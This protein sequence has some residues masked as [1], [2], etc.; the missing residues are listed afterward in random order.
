MREDEFG[1]LIGK[2]DDSRDFFRVP[3]FLNDL[4]ACHEMERA[5]WI[6]NLE[7]LHNDADVNREWKEYLARLHYNV[8]ATA[9][10]RSESFLK[11]LNLYTESDEQA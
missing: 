8:H 6:G 3:D 1:V 9:A 11:T 7:R 10:E 2:R 4:N 5:R